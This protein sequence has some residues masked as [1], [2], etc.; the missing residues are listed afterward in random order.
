MGSNPI[1]HPSN[2]RLLL[3]TVFLLLCH[4]LRKVK[5][6]VLKAFL[7]VL[8]V[9]T[10]A[11]PRHP[12]HASLIPPRA[13]LRRLLPT[14]CSALCLPA[15]SPAAL[16]P[17]LSQGERLTCAKSS[18]DRTAFFN[19]VLLTCSLACRPAPSPLARRKRCIGAA[20]PARRRRWGSRRRRGAC[21][22][23]RGCACAKTAGVGPGKAGRRLHNAAKYA[24]ISLYILRPI[25]RKDRL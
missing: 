6:S 2:S 10:C 12:A 15:P 8:D 20:R 11:I 7:H 18:C 9:P 3:Q 19:L 21:V 16:P 14:C 17:P 4:P 25:R 5:V 24:T 13:A 23:K 22:R 1:T